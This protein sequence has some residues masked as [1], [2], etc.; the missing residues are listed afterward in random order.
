MLNRI[1]DIQ[2]HIFGKTGLWAP[3]EKAQEFEREVTGFLSAP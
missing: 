1:P 3:W 2:L